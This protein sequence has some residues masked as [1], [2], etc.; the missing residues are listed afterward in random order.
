MLR[1]SFKPSLESLENRLVP[2]RMIPAPVAPINAP[3]P[4]P[5]QISTPNYNAGIVGYGDSAQ[6]GNG[7]S[8][9]AVPGSSNEYSFSVRLFPPVGHAPWDGKTLTGTLTF[10]APG[11]RRNGAI[12]LSGNLTLTTLNGS[13]LSF[14]LSGSVMSNAQFRATLTVTGGTGREYAGA[15]G[16]GTLTAGQVTLGAGGHIAFRFGCQLDLPAL[17]PSGP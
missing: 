4:P 1:R 16:T 17:P 10:G 2:A 6:G 5:G 3:P 13:T 9:T 15:T 7:N 12:T 14:S 8:L 11:S